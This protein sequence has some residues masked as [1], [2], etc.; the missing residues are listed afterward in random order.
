MQNFVDLQQPQIEEEDLEVL[1]TMEAE[2]DTVCGVRSGRKSRQDDT[3]GSV[4][5]SV[6]IIVPVVHSKL[7]LTRK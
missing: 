3:T 5:G 2:K 4:S 1:K 6:E 7:R